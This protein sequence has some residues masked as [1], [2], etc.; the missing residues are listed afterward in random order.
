MKIFDVHFTL[1]FLFYT[2][3]HT[4]CLVVAGVLPVWWLWS[5]V[6]MLAVLSLGPRAILQ[7]RIANCWRMLWIYIPFAVVIGAT[8]V[9]KLPL[10]VFWVAHFVLCEIFGALQ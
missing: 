7:S 4:V 10:Q 1:Q 6:P 8:I 3:P 9:F 5:A 2:F